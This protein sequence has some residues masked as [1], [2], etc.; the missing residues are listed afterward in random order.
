MPISDPDGY[1]EGH[2]RRVFEDLFRP[3]CVIAGY[4]AVR[5]DDAQQ[6]NLIHLDVL[7][8]LLD[9]P[10]VLCDLSARNPNVMF[11]L[12]LRQ[13]FDKPVVLVQE[14]GTPSI[15]DIALLRITPYRR[16]R[17]YN[18]VIE[19]QTRIAGALIATREAAVRGEGANS[20]VRMLAL[21]RVAAYPSLGD[22][23][24]GSVVRLVRAELGRLRGD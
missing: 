19:D 18:E 12:G 21:S 3:A 24:A 15:F 20:I 10:M 23:A 6:T 17:V 1:G 8:R 22:D 13:A 2:F 7:T 14:L 11:E 16:G 9:S 4:T 5:A